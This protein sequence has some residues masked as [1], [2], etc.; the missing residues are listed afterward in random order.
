M[1][2]L[3]SL[4]PLA[5]ESISDQSDCMTWEQATPT[6]PQASKVQQQQAQSPQ[7][8]ERCVKNLGL[9]G[10]VVG[11]TNLGNTCYLNA[12]VQLLLACQPFMQELRKQPGMGTVH[13]KSDENINPEV[14]GQTSQ[15]LLSASHF[16]NGPLGFALKQA[17]IHANGEH[18]R[19][20]FPLA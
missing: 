18:L 10:P 6:L 11:L 17:I 3:P 7:G 12:A 9:L 1:P 4:L 14:A 13:H 8:K 20:E 15:D 5:R 19:A 16:G 2:P